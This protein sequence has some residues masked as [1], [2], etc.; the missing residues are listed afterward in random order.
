MFSF[1]NFARIASQLVGFHLGT[2]YGYFFYKHKIKLVLKSLIDHG[3]DVICTNLSGAHQKVKRSIDNR[4]KRFRSIIKM[5]FD[6]YRKD[7][8]LDFETKFAQIRPELTEIHQFQ[9]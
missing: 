4:T 5:S 1:G 6:F 2:L 3:S 8:N 7:S 9:K